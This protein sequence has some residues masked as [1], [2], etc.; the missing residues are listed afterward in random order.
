MKAWKKHKADIRK[1]KAMEKVARDVDAIIHTAAEVAVTTSL[2]D[3]RTDFE[4]NV[5]GTF[6][7]LEAARVIKNN[8]CVIFYSTNK[9]YK[10][11]VN[12]IAVVEREKKYEF[13]DEKYYGDSKLA[14]D[15]YV[16]DYGYV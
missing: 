11:N 8:L 7:V 16:Q 13:T 2:K 10:S 5:V 14:G 6:N 15:I 9:V 4:I 1:A 3:P 12:K